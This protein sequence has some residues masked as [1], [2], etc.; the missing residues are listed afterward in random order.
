MP[1]GWP[2]PGASQ[3]VGRRRR[4]GRQ[5]GPRAAP[6]WLHLQ[7]RRQPPA[8]GAENRG[9]GAPGG[10][11]GLRCG[12][13]LACRP[14]QAVPAP[15]PRGQARLLA[16]LIPPSLLSFIPQFKVIDYGIAKLSAKLAAASGGQQST[17]GGAAM[18]R[19]PP[20]PPWL[21]QRVSWDLDALT[22]RLSARRP[23]KR[24]RRCSGW[25]RFSGRASEFILSR[26][27]RW[28]AGALP[29]SGN[30]P[31]LLPA[32]MLHLVAAHPPLLLLL[33]ACVA[34]GAPGD[35]QRARRDHVRLAALAAR[36]LG[37]A[38]GW[39]G[40]AAAPPAFRCL[41][42]P[43]PRLHSPLSPQPGLPPAVYAAAPA[44]A[45]RAQ[46]PRQPRTRQPGGQQ[47]RHGNHG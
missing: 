40:W 19:R 8:A 25:T 13:G 9:G 47:P 44:L 35:G 24:R 34:E 21:A 31:R 39:V 42:L 12:I 17:V 14:T 4:R 22:P 7:R 16:R 1:D 18:P 26:T 38:G 45:A 43:A 33:P 29:F 23:D 10:W 5:R 20:L 6:A 27:A 46:R 41:V 32:P 3:R 28:A 11:A 30:G 37:A 2:R 15:L 36:R